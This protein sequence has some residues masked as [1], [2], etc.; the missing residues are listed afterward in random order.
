MNLAVW[1]PALFVLGATGAVG[2]VL[3]YGRLMRRA[4]LPRYPTD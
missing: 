4:R 2:V 1:L 3:T